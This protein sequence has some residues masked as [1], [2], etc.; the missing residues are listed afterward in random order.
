MTGAIDMSQ[1]FSKRPK[2]CQ[3]NQNEGISIEKGV[4]FSILAISWEI[5]NTIYS[6]SLKPLYQM[7][8][9]GK[10]MTEAKNMSQIY[11]K[12]PKVCQ[13]IPN[14]GIFIK[15]GVKFRI[16]AI[17]WEISNTIYLKSLRPLY[18]MIS[19]GK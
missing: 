5:S 13:N 17:S 4:K 18:Q 11:S 6:K 12:G 2:V 8:S 16:L 3:N 10:W 7:I 14:E 15:K 9:W 1:I 19:W